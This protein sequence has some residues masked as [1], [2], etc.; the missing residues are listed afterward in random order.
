MRTSF[1][2][3]LALGV[4]AAFAAPAQ[5]QITDNIDATATVL[6]ALTVTGDASL[7]FGNIA[8]SQ[9]K[10]VAAGAA[11]S[12][13]FSLNGAPGS[14]VSFRFNALPANLS[15]AGLTL[16]G[17]TGLHRDA[18]TAAGATAFAPTAGVSESVT[19]NAADGS[20]YVWL[21]ATLTA[22]GVVAPGSYTQPVVLEVFYN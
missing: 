20:Y 22:A 5:A 11:A 9:I 16:S 14:S 17:W 21:G 12:G 1:K 7:A 10:S 15:I 13:H 18:N 8:P 2:F 3:V 4:M 19:M 6:Q